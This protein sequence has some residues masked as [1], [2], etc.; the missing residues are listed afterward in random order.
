MRGSPP[1]THTTPTL[2][3]TFPT[4]P[5]AHTPEPSNA[6][7]TS[8]LAPFPTPTKN[9]QLGTTAAATSSSPDKQLHVLGCAHLHLSVCCR[10]TTLTLCCAD[11]PCDTCQLVRQLLLLGEV[12]RGIQAGSDRRAGLS[13]SVPGGGE[14]SKP[15]GAAPRSEHPRRSWRRGRGPPG[16]SDMRPWMGE[17]RWQ[18]CARC[19]QL[20]PLHRRGGL[21]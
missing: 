6:H 13:G 12:G 19:T 2:L 5:Q 8:R 3:A 21:S 16:R 10:P 7:L 4:P 15:Y 1:G 20:R 17:G 9:A 11:L 18:G 14:G